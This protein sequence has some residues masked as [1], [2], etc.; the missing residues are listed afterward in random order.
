MASIW[1]FCGRGTVLLRQMVQLMV[2][3]WTFW[4]IGMALLRQKGFA[5]TNTPGLYGL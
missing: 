2:V 3:I 1:S 5:R 4:R